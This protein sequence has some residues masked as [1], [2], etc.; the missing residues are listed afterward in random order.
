MSAR[1][2]NTEKT[3]KPNY[4]AHFVLR[5]SNLERSLDWYHK[6]LGM[7]IVQS[8]GKL[9]FLTYDDEHHRLALAETPIQ[10]TAPPG[11]PGVDHV[12][13]T[14]DSLGDLLGHYVRLREL[15]IKP[16]LPINHGPTTSMYYDDPDGNRVRVPG[17]QLRHA[18]RTQ[19]LVRDRHLREEPDRR[20]VRSRQARG[21]LREGRSD[22]G[23]DPAGLGMTREELIGARPPTGA[24]GGRSRA[25]DR[26][27]APRAPRRRSR[28]SAT[29]VCFGCSCRRPTAATPSNSALS[30]S[31]R[32]RSARAAAR[33]RGACRSARSTTGSSRASPKPRSRRCS[34]TTPTP[35]C[36]RIH[37]HRAGGSR[38]RWLPPD[39]AVGLRERLRPLG[40]RGARGTGHAR[41]RRSAAGT[42]DLRRPPG[43]LP[44]RRQ[45]VR[46]GPA[47]HGQQAGRRGRRVRPRRVDQP[48]RQGH[49]GAASGPEPAADQ[50]GPRPWASPACRSGSRA[51]R[52]RASRSGSPPSSARATSAAPTSRWVR[53]TGWRS[54]R[55]RSTP[56]SS[57]C[58]ATAPRWRRPPPAA[59]RRATTSAAATAATPRGPSGSAPRP[60]AACCRPPG[61][62]RSSVTACSSGRCAT[63]QIMTAHMAGAWDQ[64]RESY[65]RARLG[66]EVQDPVF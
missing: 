4:F 18:R 33:R 52:C 19:G 64:S 55:S 15:G 24:A 47:G 57:S 35:S 63:P 10:E 65:A 5:V 11:C 40:A 38:R 56:P 6:V 48:D 8:V 60:W 34:G 25:E 22:R 21:A 50:L 12:A 39:R 27:A 62:A 7:E 9:A 2:L 43:G 3:V 51:E 1:T 41:A 20:A 42:R 49:A 31:S 32:A 23:A 61:R 53:T 17:R 28:P 16:V 30:S 46:R 37:A 59:F 44:H 29:R 26:R 13:Y 14:M 58:C 66:L 36:A 45:L 54:P